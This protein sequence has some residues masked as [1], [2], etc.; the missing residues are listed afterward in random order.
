VH[1]GTE[2]DADL[3]D[4][5]PRPVRVTSNSRTPGLSG[6]RNTGILAVGIDLVAFLDDDDS[7][8]PGKL[9]AQVDA[10]LAEPGAEMVSTAMRVT[11][12]DT[13]SVRLAGQDHVTYPELLRSRM[14]MLHSSSFLF[15][16][17]ALVHDI[18]LMDETQPG[19]MCEDWD[20]LLRASKRHPVVH[21]DVPLTEVL[22]GTSYFVD[23]WE[24]KVTGRE[25]MLERHPDIARDPVGGARVFGQLA[26]A[27]AALGQRR[28]AVRWAVRTVRT[29]PAEPRAYLALA[30]A[31]GAVTARRVQDVLHRRGHGV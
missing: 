9:T 27:H 22:W 1:D 26:F 31:S 18:G 25:W 15:R 5:G 8:A 3:V 24:T 13:V 12:G 28:Q 6:G 7:W 21:V 4:D 29:R 17:E 2:P 19:S 23:R 16:R 14:A 10:L 20:V 11:Y 30:V